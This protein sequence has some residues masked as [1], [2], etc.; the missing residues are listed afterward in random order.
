MRRI[1]SI[2]T[3]GRIQHDEGEVIH[4]VADKLTDHSTLLAK[5]ACP[6]DEGIKAATRDFRQE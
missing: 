4:V 5:M 3:G 2:V 1:Q 6:G